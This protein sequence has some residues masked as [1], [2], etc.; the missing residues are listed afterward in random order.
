MADVA[1]ITRFTKAIEL[2]ADGK[3]YTEV[4]KTLGISRRTLLHWRKDPAFMI[5]QDE[6]ADGH[7]HAARHEL[8]ALMAD[9]VRALRDSIAPG[10]TPEQQKCNDMRARHAKTVLDRAGVIPR[11]IEG[12]SD[13]EIEELLQ[14]LGYVKAEQ[15]GEQVH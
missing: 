10:Q 2:L 1:K 9:A 13:E 7:L 4:A 15:Q 6:V 11:A 3:S 14:R 8:R 5:L 12:V